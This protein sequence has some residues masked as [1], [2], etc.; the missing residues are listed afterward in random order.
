ML[1]CVHVYLDILSAVVPFL[2]VVKARTVNGL[3]DGCDETR[4]KDTNPSDS[5]AEVLLLKS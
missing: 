1:C 4:V 5:P 3:S 2:S